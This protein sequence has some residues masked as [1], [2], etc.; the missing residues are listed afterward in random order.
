AAQTAQNYY[1]QL[2]KGDYQAFVAG[3]YQPHAL[4]PGYQE[5]LVANAKM[6]VVQQQEAH[7]GIVRVKALDARAD[8]S[9]QV[10]N[11]FLNLTFGDRTTEEIVVPMVEKKGVWYMR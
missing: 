6:Y 3:R 10:A 9:R 7:K 5:Q 8:T 1:T 2:L 4:P 11:V